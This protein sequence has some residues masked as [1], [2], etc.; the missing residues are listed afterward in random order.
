MAGALTAMHTLQVAAVRVLA[1]SLLIC[2]G[3]ELGDDLMKCTT[4]CMQY[5]PSVCVLCVSDVMNLRS[6]DF[7][8]AQPPSCLS[9]SPPRP[10]SPRA[11]L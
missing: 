11:R 5:T 9:P 2:G 7:F 8:A 6:G 10:P 1:V 3:D 4:Y